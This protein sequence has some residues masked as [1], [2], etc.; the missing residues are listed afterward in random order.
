[1][2]LDQLPADTLHTVLYRQ[3]PEKET[4]EYYL[5][6]N[7]LTVSEQFICLWSSFQA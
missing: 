7:K 1:M 2:Q 4:Q 5:A 6:K 3:V